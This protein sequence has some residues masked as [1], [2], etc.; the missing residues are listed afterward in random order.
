MS[1]IEVTIV[2]YGLHFLGILGFLAYVVH[3]VKRIIEPFV[4]GNR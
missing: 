4:G 2:R 1:E 3:E